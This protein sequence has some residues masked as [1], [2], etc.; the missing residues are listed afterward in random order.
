MMMPVWKCEDWMWRLAAIIGLVY[1]LSTVYFIRIVYAYHSLPGAVPASGPDAGDIA[2]AV[3]LCLLIVCCW[4]PMLRWGRAAWLWG[5]L[6]GLPLA[7]LLVGPDW[8]SALC[9][10]LGPWFVSVYEYPYHW[11]RLPDLVLA[12]VVPAAL[13][14]SQI[15]MIWEAQ[16]VA[17]WP[18]DAD[19]LSLPGRKFH[20]WDQAGS[21][22]RVFALGGGAAGF[23]LSAW[24][25]YLSI[26]NF[27]PVL[28][29]GSPPYIVQIVS[30][31]GYTIAAVALAGVITLAWTS[32]VATGRGFLF[33]LAVWGLALLNCSYDVGRK[34]LTTGGKEWHISVGL[35]FVFLLLAVSQIWV[36]WKAHKLAPPGRPRGARH[37]PSSLCN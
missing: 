22:W 16:R 24:M 34:Y 12:L 27:L 3:R 29:Y 1:A 13:M 30:A 10:Y 35:I 19:R 33:W 5:A 6:C 32:L 36:A 17:E 28:G 21:T 25:V 8:A 9:I 31:T 15:W 23:S 2:S 7:L 11:N 37:G 4:L 26:G 20:V 18:P 14:A